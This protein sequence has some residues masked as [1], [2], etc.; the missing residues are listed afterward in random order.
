MSAPPQK[1]WTLPRILCDPFATFLTA[2]ALNCPASPGPEVRLEEAHKAAEKLNVDVRLTLELP[3]RRLFDSFEA[4]SALAKEFRESRPRVVI[5]FCDK[6]PLASPDHWQAM[7]VTDAAIFNSQLTK[8]ESYFDDLPVHRVSTQLFFSLGFAGPQTP[9]SAQFV[10]DI[11][12]TM[13]IKTEALRCCKT[14]FPPA[15]SLTLE[16][17]RAINT[18][19]GLAAGCMAAEVFLRPP[20]AQNE[21]PHANP[22]W[23]SREAEG[24][25]SY[26]S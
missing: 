8:W 13:E 3:N 12:D 2:T 20:V 4:R 6:T 15:K 1:S 7:Q 26:A 5:G 22:V 19:E 14:Q 10:L 25:E 24:I 23:R 18:A 17:L 9:T 16:G 21:Q 11:S